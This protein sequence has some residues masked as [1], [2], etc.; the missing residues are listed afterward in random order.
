MAYDISGNETASWAPPATE[1]DG[2]WKGFNGSGSGSD[3]GFKGGLALD[4]KTNVRVCKDRCDYRRVQDAVN[5]APD[6]GTEKFVIR[7]E[8][9]IYEESVRVPLWKKH[10]VFVGDGMGKTVITGHQ[11]VGQHGVST[12]NTATVGKSIIYTYIKKGKYFNKK[13]KKKILT[14]NFYRIFLLDALHSLYFYHIL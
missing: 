6:N 7:I 9:G 4:M 13:K 10:V 12:Y 2:F 5:A 8:E 11:S 1:R 14:C 3:P